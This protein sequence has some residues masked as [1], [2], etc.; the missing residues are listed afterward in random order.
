MKH[1]T[2]TYY[3]ATQKALMWDRWKDG[4]TL[5]QIGKRFDRIRPAK[6]PCYP[7]IHVRGAP[8]V[9]LFACCALGGRGQPDNER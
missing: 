7:N 9:T 1:R 4:C 3:T 5:Q 6:S 2:R 8:E